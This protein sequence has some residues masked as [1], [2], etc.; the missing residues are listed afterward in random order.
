MLI[1]VNVNVCS[2]LTVVIW[3]DSCSVSELTGEQGTDRLEEPRWEPR[4]EL[5]SQ[6]SSARFSS[7]ECEVSVS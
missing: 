5:V 3:T 1:S 6:L 4:W 2:Y 7:S